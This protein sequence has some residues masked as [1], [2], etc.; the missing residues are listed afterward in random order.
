MRRAI[1]HTQRADV[2][3]VRG[4]PR[5]ARVEADIR[6]TG[7]ERGGPKAIVF[8]RIGNLEYFAPRDGVAAKGNVARRLG[9]FQPDV[10]LE[11]LPRG[12]NQRYGG[13]GS[14]A[15]LRGETREVVEVS[16]G[17]Q[18]EDVVAPQGGEALG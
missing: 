5:R 6:G 16:L 1:Q 10:A 7:G 18:V 17:R 12:I 8:Q 13:N 3:P 2:Q 4:D 9:H 11:P 15:N 14:A